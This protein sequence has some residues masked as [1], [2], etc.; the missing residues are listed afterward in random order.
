M[1][2][3]NYTINEMVLCGNSKIISIEV[4]HASYSVIGVGFFVGSRHDP[5]GK[6]GIVQRKPES[7]S[8]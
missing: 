4:P 2:L 1:R 8:T 6:S 5:V 7:I 3:V